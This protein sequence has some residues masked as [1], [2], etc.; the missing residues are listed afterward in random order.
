MCVCV[1]EL[2]D[3]DLELKVRERVPT[4]LDDA[5]R[6]ALQMETYAKAAERKKKE[7]GNMSHTRH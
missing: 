6:I 7:Q 2:N 3:V 1:S 5:L 4:T